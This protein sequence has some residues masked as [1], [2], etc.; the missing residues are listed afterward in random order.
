MKI[1]PALFHAA[2]IVLL[3]FATHPGTASDHP[4]GTPAAQSIKPYRMIVLTDIGAEVDDSES[5]VRLLLY[6]DTIDIQGLVATTSVW[7]RTSVSPDLIEGIVR[8]YSQV[9][10][11]LVKHDANY[12]TAEFL[13][14]L[15]KRGLPEYGMK[16]VGPG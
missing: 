5:M 6:S 12:P 7:K 4:S 11:N 13:R 8:A 9:H 10:S 2:A 1:R 3:G 14:A 16:G 15:I